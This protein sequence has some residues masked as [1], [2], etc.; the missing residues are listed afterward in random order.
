MELTKKQKEGLEI[1]IERYKKR[2]PYTCIAGYAGTGKSTLVN[3]IITA[4][5]L[6]EESVGYVAFTGKAAE[7]LRQKGCSNACTAHRLLYYTTKNKKGNFIFKPRKTLEQNYK[8]IVIDEVS[9]IPKDMWNLFLSHKIPIIALGDPG[10]LPPVCKEDENHVLDNPHIFLDE[11]MRQALD[12]EII[13][14]SMNIREGNKI[15]Y[16]VGKDVMVIPIHKIQEGMYNWASQIIVATNK[17]RDRVNNLIRKIKGYGN[18]PVK[19]E[20]LISL[21][22]QW[23]IFDKKGESNLVNGT[24]CYLDYYYEDNITYP[25]RPNQKTI[26]VFSSSF[27][28]ENNEEFEGIFVDK[29]FLLEDKKIL[30]AADEFFI[31]NSMIPTMPQLPLEFNYGYAI[32]CHKAQGSQWDKVLIFEENFPNEITEHKRWLYTAVTRGINKVILVR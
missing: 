8:L 1:A 7:V 12:N 29:N 5:Q 17:K 21:S 2:E 14:L 16:F 4:L 25:L 30:T 28:T 22:N 11:I 10:Q 32:T 26:P 19:G 24:I 27:T 3:F 18:L 20:K 23:E 6:P 15:D 9:M 13:K 31:S